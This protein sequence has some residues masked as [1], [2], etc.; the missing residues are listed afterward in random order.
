MA[1][2]EKGK[3]TTKQLSEE[4]LRLIDQKA[5]TYVQRD[6]QH[7]SIPSGGLPLPDNDFDHEYYEKFHNNPI[8]NCVAHIY[9]VGNVPKNKYE[10]DSDLLLVYLNGTLLYEDID[11]A[12]SP[13]SEYIKRLD[14]ST[15]LKVGDPYVYIN[16]IPSDVPEENKHLYR[17]FPSNGNFFYFIIVKG[18]RADY[19]SIQG[20]DIIDG[21][22]EERKLDSTL[23][24]KIDAKLDDVNLDPI[25]NDIDVINTKLVNIDPSLA[26]SEVPVGTTLNAT[27]KYILEQ[28]I[29]QTDFYKKLKNAN[30]R[31]VA[32]R[33]KLYAYKGQIFIGDNTDN[34]FTT[35]FLLSSIIEG[36]SNNGLKVSLIFDMTESIINTFGGPSNDFFT[37]YT[38]FLIDTLTTVSGINSI[39][40]YIDHAFL[41][42]D[43][44]SLSSNEEKE[45]KVK[46]MVDTLRTK[47]AGKQIQ[48]GF[49]TTLQ[50]M[51]L[52]NGITVFDDFDIIGIN[53]EPNVSDTASRNEA[54][55]AMRHVDYYS[56]FDMIDKIC[57]DNNKRYIVTGMGYNK[58]V[59]SQDQYMINYIQAAFD[60]F[61]HSDYCDEF[62]L[63]DVTYSS[64]YNWMISDATYT[65]VKNL[66]GK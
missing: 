55:V 9:G 12:V 16:T 46:E 33:L 43:C 65:A 18:A 14:N 48:Y 32:L 63:N 39:A 58:S 61:K 57:K 51:E 49:I 7:N 10:K 30:I 15:W 50:T 54:F 45:Y 38:K 17:K 36:L 25:R 3:I 59:K 28:S 44:P 37:M 47:T 34:N 42:T 64:N 52:V 13:N 41:F 8:R 22:I 19:G 66:G 53:N 56:I 29:E 20:S 5:V 1:N 11:Y 26:A 6:V 23:K 31:R 24:R 40:E 35:V 62:W 2:K 21:T 4:V 27:I 60:I